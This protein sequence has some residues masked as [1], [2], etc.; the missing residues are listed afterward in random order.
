MSLSKSWLQQLPIDDVKTIKSVSGG[1]INDSYMLE[2]QTNKYFMK[3]QPKRG[4]EFFAHEVEGLEL[5][6]KV[7][8]TPKIVATGEVGLDGFLILNWI[9]TGSGSQVELGKMVAKVHQQHAKQFGLDHN[10]T[11]GKLPKNN[12]WQSDWTTFYLN[13]RLQPLV[14]LAIKKGRWNDWR[15]KQFQSMSNQFKKYYS[16]HDVTPSLLHGDLW[17]GNYMFTSDGTPM[18]IDPDVFYG[19]RELDIAMTTIFGGFSQEFYQGYNSVY[20]LKIGVDKRLGWYQ[21]N[22]LLAHLNLFGETYGPM[23][24][25]ILRAY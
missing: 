23:V 19:D 11:A 14:D 6:G 12:T 22:Y 2:T 25:Q 17:S 3:V 5:L 18:L 8:N 15:K 10:F 13:Q 1:D 9:D 20:P 21:L 7:A 4:K 24:D 16:T